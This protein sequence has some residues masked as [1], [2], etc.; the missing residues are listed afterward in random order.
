MQD[1]TQV[2]VVGGGPAGATTATLL[3]RSGVEVTLA[4]RETFPRYHIG[5]S[6]LPSC[7]KILDLMG[8]RDKLREFGFQ[9]KEGVYFEWG[10]PSW[11]ARFLNLEGIDDKHGYQVARAE[12]DQ[13]LLEHAK[14]QG[15]H[16]FEGTAVKR[17]EFDGDRPV[18]ATCAQEGGE[19]T[20]GFDVLVDASGRAGLL[21]NRHQRDRVFHQAFRNVA[22]W[23]YWRGAGQLPTDLV[24]ATG[25]CAVPDGWFWAIPLRDGTVSLGL[26]LHRDT[27]Q[28]TRGNSGDLRAFYLDAIAACPTIRDLVSDAALVS[29]VCAE[30]DYSY[31]SD[32]FAGPGYF[33][34]GDAA[35][36]LDPLLSTGV[37]LAQYSAVLAAASIGSL[38]RSEVTEDEARAFYQDSYR[39]AY[40]R[41]FTLVS[42]YYQQYGGQRTY[43]WE[44]QQLT[45]RDYRDAELSQAFLNIIT[46]IEDFKDAEA[47]AGFVLDQMT[48]AHTEAFK[49]LRHPKKIAGFNPAE[50]ERAKAKF[51]LLDRTAHR[52]SLT[53]DAAVHGLYAVF[54]PRLGLARVVPAA[55]AATTAGGQR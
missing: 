28:A 38:L 11:E 16:V 33:I 2:L 4:E 9:R 21:A 19:H 26:V 49:V 39:Q 43:F 36:F 8:M 51:E 50:Q 24:G 1:K 31:A 13:L 35:C 34:A 23:G 47:A 30:Q 5:E 54:E 12:F 14:S 32:R 6:L 20:I 10:G 22:V 37:H 44:A 45:A 40:L 52:F 46:G 48:E 25:V 27:F 29:E 15:V 18:Q 53:E 7:M 17:L 3:A 42:F 55:L 41:F